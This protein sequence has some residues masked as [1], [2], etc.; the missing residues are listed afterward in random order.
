M[1]T[2]TYG[3]ARPMKYEDVKPGMLIAAQWGSRKVLGLAFA[4]DRETLVAV[5]DDSGDNEPE[6]PYVLDL[7]DLHTSAVMI[8]GHREIV[9]A[10]GDAPFSLLPQRRI[11]KEGLV[12]CSDGR[13]GVAVSHH[14]FG[15]KKFLML[16]FETGEP[17]G[18]VSQVAALPD[19]Q[20]FVVEE[21]QTQRRL[22]SA[23]T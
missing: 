11:G 18:E 13:V 8:P 1:T 21:G 22:V 17:I 3:F 14:D 5:F 12:I 6:P 10:D 16:D 19:W 9:P 23:G 7:T 2:R 4:G 20:L 15:T